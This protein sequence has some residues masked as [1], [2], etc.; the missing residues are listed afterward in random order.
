[1]KK[2]YL[3]IITIILLGIFS[4]RRVI[5]LPF[6]FIEIEYVNKEKFYEKPKKYEYD[7][8]LDS[9]IKEIK[10]EV[11]NVRDIVYY[12][13]GNV[14]RNEKNVLTRDK[15]FKSICS[16]SSKILF[17]K[18]KQKNIPTR[19][20]WMNG[21]TVTEV[22]H[23]ETGWFLVDSYGDIIIKDCL[24]DYLS[25]IEIK[26]EKCLDVIDMTK[27]KRLGYKQTNYLNSND[28][29]YKYNQLYVV[30]DEKYLYQFHENT[31]DPLNILNFIIGKN[32]IGKGKQLILEDFN[33]VGN[34]G[35]FIF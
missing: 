29:V 13:E 23:Q 30:I 17:H 27:D 31:K 1:M 14:I 28:N 2:K 18:L 11:S 35:V 3:I 6:P 4:Y 26:E 19:V 24:G 16:E 10:R 8:P 7:K 15:K 20:V 34:F 12:G 25:I 9:L 21:H 33:K 22:F 32:K 5:Y